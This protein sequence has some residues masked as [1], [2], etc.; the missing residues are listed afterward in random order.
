MFTALLAVCTVI[1]GLIWPVCTGAISNV[2][3][4]S[5]QGKVMG[6]SQSMLSLTMMFASVL[7]G[8][9]LHAHSMIPFL[10]SALSTVVA[11]A[12]VLGTSFKGY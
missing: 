2:A 12:L 3:P 10:F 11:A 6:L 9:F 8:V 7:G 4:P 1:S 5:M